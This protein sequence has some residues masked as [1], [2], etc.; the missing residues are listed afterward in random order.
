MTGKRIW[1]SF[2]DFFRFFFDFFVE[3]RICEKE[4]T[5]EGGGIKQFVGHR[6]G[7]KRANMI[8]NIKI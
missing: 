4:K 1:Q 6:N 3:K 5:V 7:Y 2:F 8:N